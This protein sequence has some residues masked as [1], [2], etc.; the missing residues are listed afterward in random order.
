MSKLNGV[1]ATE[2]NRSLET[3]RACPADVSSS[4]TAAAHDAPL[5]GSLLAFGLHLWCRFPCRPGTGWYGRGACGSTLGLAEGG[6]G[7]VLKTCGGERAA[8][9]EGEE[10]PAGA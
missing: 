9:R 6:G 2:L 5:L 7:R 10:V 1:F 4:R 3:T 8:L